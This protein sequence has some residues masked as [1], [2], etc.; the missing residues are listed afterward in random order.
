MAQL[1]Q[2]VPLP[3]FEFSDSSA[4]VVPSGHQFEPVEDPQHT[5][6]VACRDCGME[7]WISKGLVHA[8]RQDVKPCRVPN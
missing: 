8:Y 2:R 5:N 6:L 1:L 7:G 3:K 4:R